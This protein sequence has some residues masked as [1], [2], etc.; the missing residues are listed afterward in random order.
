MPMIKRMRKLS[1]SR[2]PDCTAVIAAAGTS[3]RMGNVDKLFFEINGKP[4]LAHT[5]AAFQNSELINEIIVVVREEMLERAGEL[6]KKYDVGKVSKIVV[7]GERRIDS[8]TNGVYAASKKSSLIAI[9]DGARPCLTDEVIERAVKA[10]AR[11]HAAAPGVA[12]SSTIKRVSN[13]I[14]LETVDRS[15]LFEIQTPQV[16]SAELIK[17]ALKSVSRKSIDLTD[18]CAA[19]ELLGAAV[20]ITEGARS[21]IKITENEDIQLAE[22]ILSGLQAKA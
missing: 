4:V 20:Y 13:G 14:V 2:L 8:V 1:I 3:K 19:V 12:V 7:G 6:C 17:A 22:K 11:H 18:D 5:L 15:D 10:A 16:F 21:N 9:H